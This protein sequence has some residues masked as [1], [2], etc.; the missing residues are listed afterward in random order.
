MMTGIDMI[1]ER[2]YLLIESFCAHNFREGKA[3]ESQMVAT[4]INCF[5][6]QDCGSFKYIPTDRL[7]ADLGLPNDAGIFG[8]VRFTDE[9]YLLQTCDGPLAIWS[10]AETPPVFPK[11]H[12]LAQA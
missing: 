8:Y 10:G 12:A 6:V 4:F 2:A 7:N 11:K 9:S 1:A 5:D 3:L